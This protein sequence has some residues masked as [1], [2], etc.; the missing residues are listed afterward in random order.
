MFCVCDDQTARVQTK[1]FKLTEI[2]W[3]NNNK[4][5]TPQHSGASS[6]PLWVCMCVVCVCVMACDVLKRVVPN[7]QHTPKDCSSAHKPS[8]LL[9]HE[10]RNMLWTLSHLSFSLSDMINNL[11]TA[12]VARSFTSLRSLRSQSCQESRLGFPQIG[13]VHVCECLS[14]LTY[15]SLNHGTRCSA[16]K[17][18]VYRVVRTVDLCV[19]V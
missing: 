11:V 4:A 19:N 15:N 7:S 18:L 8:S 14:A 3:S 9:T 12:S 5:L 10:E 2:R 6:R 16:S 17:L 1:N 13:Y